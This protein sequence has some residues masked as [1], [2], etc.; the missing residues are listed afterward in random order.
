MGFA[1]ALDNREFALLAEMDPP[2]GS[3]LQGFIDT[4]MRIKGRVTSVVVT[5]GASAIMRMTPLA[6]C[7]ALIDNQ[8]E[9]VMILNGRDRNRIS[10]QGDLLS[11]WALGVR[12][13]LLK[14]GQDPSVGDQPMAL[15]S[16]DL[17]LDMMIKSVT[18]L[19]NGRDLAGEDL[20]G[21]TEFVIGAHLD[22][23]DDVGRNRGMADRLPGLAEQGVRFVVLGP[24]YDLNLVDLF[25][26][27]AEDAG[28]VLLASVMYLKSVA[29]IRYINNL[30]GVPDVPH[31]FLKQMM[32]APVK[33]TAG[34]EIAAGFIKDAQTRCQGVVLIALGWG[35]RL[36]EFIDLLGR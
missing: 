5:D 19:N 18:A 11:A 2:K 23:S 17:D 34:M 9:P 28:V 29:M 10:F 15:D 7:R 25:A 14:R 1:S 31:E 35:A 13:V 3:D 32:S 30:A 27:R 4:A 26:K 8:V 20:T 12:Y 22:V 16:G 36:P 21:K 33:Q 24:T 6:P